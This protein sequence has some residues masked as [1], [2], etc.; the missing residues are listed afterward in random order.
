[1]FGRV[2]APR[3]MSINSF[4]SEFDV[5]VVN[6]GAILVD[7]RF[8]LNSHLVAKIFGDCRRDGFLRDQ[9]LFN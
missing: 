9:K 5:F 6:L 8:F 4:I 1:M 7:G 3:D 2:S